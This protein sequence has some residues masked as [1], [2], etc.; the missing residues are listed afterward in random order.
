MAAK[1]QAFPAACPLPMSGC[2]I[3]DRKII[4]V[5]FIFK[6]QSR[7]GQSMNAPGWR[8]EK[9]TSYLILLDQ[10]TGKLLK[11][12]QTYLLLSAI[13]VL[14]VQPPQR[15]ASSFWNTR[16]QGGTTKRQ[17]SPKAYLC[18]TINIS[19]LFKSHKMVG[20]FQT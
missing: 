2:I 15:S 5:V 6:K 16:P 14:S 9:L 11:G 7:A 18:T 19:F 1:M 12:Q 8:R 20:I 4:H 10:S 17:G 13:K 3:R